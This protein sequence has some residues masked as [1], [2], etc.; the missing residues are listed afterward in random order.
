MN[1]KDQMNQGAKEYGAEGGGQFQ[2]SKSGKYSLRILCQPIAIATHFFGQGNPSHVCV[3]KEKGCPFHTSDHKKP[4]V[5]FIT[6]VIDRQ[7]ED[8]VKIAEI[9]WAVISEV[10][11]FQVE[12][13]Y[14]FE[15]YPIPY[16]ILVTVDKA[17]SPA[18][19]YKT[20]AARSNS[21]VPAEKIAE[22]EERMKEK[23]P[24][25]YVEQ[26]KSKQV[27]KMELEKQYDGDAQQQEAPDYPE[28]PE[29]EPNI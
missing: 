15:E 8:K 16:D 11:D 3:G 21:E 18:D 14:A 25:K 4:S 13:E 20:M 19:I 28:G 9:P 29:G 27:E 26:R 10:A 2:F 5:K 22:L 7:D 24:E 1:L 17:A 12:P 23:T 6:Y